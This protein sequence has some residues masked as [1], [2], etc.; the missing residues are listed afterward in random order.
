MVSG[1]SK[2]KKSR[3]LAKALSDHLAV[4]V[5]VDICCEYFSTSNMNKKNKLKATVHDIENLKE[6]LNNELSQI[7]RYHND[8]VTACLNASKIIPCSGVP[9]NCGK[10]V[11]SPMPG[12]NEIVQVK[13]ECG[14]GDGRRQVDP[15][16]VCYVI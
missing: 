11:K 9:K 7:E 14:I 5:E 10:S 4:M 2:L 6:T 3:K 15:G 16:L 13:K 8:I 12:W 1:E